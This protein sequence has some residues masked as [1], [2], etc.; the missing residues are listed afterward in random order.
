MAVNR[1]TFI[2][3]ANPDFHHGLLEHLLRN[4]IEEMLCELKAIEV[5]DTSDAHDSQRGFIEAS[6][7]VARRRR[8]LEILREFNQLF[9]KF[10]F[11]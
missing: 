2:A 6:A 3:N 4:K 7:W 1:S 5:W 11:H 9:A 10:V 8:L